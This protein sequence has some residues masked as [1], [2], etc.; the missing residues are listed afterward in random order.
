MSAFGM[1]DE[2]R[3]VLRKNRVFLIRNLQLDNMFLSYM[4][5]NRTITEDMQQKIMAS[6]SL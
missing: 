2:H 6:S 4:R 1:T 3:Q 5:E